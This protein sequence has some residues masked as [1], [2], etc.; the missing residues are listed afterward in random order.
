ML[1]DA[2]ALEIPTAGGG[3]RAPRVR[4]DPGALVDLL[5]SPLSGAGRPAGVSA[6]TDAP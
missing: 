2:A 5:L 3:A 6:A 1:E 4:R